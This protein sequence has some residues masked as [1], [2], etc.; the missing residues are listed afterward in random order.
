MT[1]VTEEQSSKTG[2]VWRDVWGAKPNVVLLSWDNPLTEGQFSEALL[3]LSTS[4]TSPVRLSNSAGI[5]LLVEIPPEHC[6]EAT[7]IY[8]DDLTL[9]VR[10]VVNEKQDPDADHPL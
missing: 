3:L 1:Q 4:V 10:E 6:T 9:K 5:T 2:L 8:G 7:V